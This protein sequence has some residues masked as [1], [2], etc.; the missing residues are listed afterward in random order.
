MVSWRATTAVLI[1]ALSLVCVTGAGP[2]LAAYSSSGS[3]TSQS[4]DTP[5]STTTPTHVTAGACH[6]YVSQG[7]LFGHSCNGQLTG[8]TVWTIISHDR[9]QLPTCW[10]VVM[11]SGD[12]ADYGLTPPAPD[13]GYLYAIQECVDPDDFSLNFPPSYQ[14][15]LQINEIVIEIKTPGRPCRAGE[16]VAEQTADHNV[17]VLTLTA[18][19][20]RL[21]D[22]TDVSTRTVPRVLIV[23]H[24]T[25]T[26]RTNETVSYSDEFAASQPGTDP[27]R[28]D[29]QVINGSAMW[30]SMTD[31]RIY[32][33][34]QG[35][36]SGNEPCTLGAHQTKPLSAADMV[37][38][39]CKECDGTATVS[40]Q[41]TT[42]ASALD[43]CW[44]TYTQ[45]S[46]VIPNTLTYP[47]L[48]QAT[49]TVYYNTGPTVT[50]AAT[51]SH[52][53]STVK[54]YDTTQLPVLDVQS[55]V[56]GTG[57]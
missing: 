12:L 42:P 26:V 36:A 38:G 47:L 13:L 18:I 20:H 16:T 9:S 30:A 25:T 29:T 41:D 31:Y 49:W 1:S 57:G 52:V 54:E 7:G 22:P 32:P 17:C 53:L 3:T 10:D 19:G 45:S 5:G 48:S 28:T 55:V 50:G 44:W 6:Y 27:R 15:N 2:S 56:I 4:T 33:Y 8:D 11:S 51:A 34:G 43:A 40:P 14:P 46:A 39:V 24:P 21:V 35:T 37:P 23:R